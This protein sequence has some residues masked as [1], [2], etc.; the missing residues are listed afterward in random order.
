MRLQTNIQNMIMNI[1]LVRNADIIKAVRTVALLI[2]R[3]IVMNRKKKN[4]WNYSFIL[5][6]ENTP[7][8]NRNVDGWMNP[9][10]YELF[11]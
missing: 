3:N 6:T 7:A 10:Q 1:V 5:N 4:I 11:L 9:L 8:S 2:N